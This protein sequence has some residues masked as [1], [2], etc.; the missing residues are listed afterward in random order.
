MMSMYFIGITALVAPE[1][2]RGVGRLEEHVRAHVLQPLRDVAQRAVG[3]ADEEH[4]HR[5]LH[6]HREHGDGGARLAMHDVRGGEVR[7]GSDASSG[8]AIPM[9]LD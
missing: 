2:E 4:H 5:H 3:Q 6:R 9:T 7:H 8:Q 1:Q